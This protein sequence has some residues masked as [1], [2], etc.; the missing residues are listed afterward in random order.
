MGVGEKKGEHT[1]SSVELPEKAALVTRA[2]LTTIILALCW[3]TLGGECHRHTVAGLDKP[4]IDPMA[5]NNID[6]R[7]YRLYHHS[8]GKREE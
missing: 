6:G 3:W 4:E 7:L 2:A 1:D 5:V 8:H